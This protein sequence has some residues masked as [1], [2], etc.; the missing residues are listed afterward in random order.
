[1]LSLRTYSGPDRRSATRVPLHAEAIV[2]S[3]GDKHLCT[4]L[5]VSATG[6]SVRIDSL[7]LL[8]HLVEIELYIPGTSMASKWL[9][10]RAAVVRAERNGKCITWGLEF[11]NPGQKNT[12]RIQIYVDGFN[13]G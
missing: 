12:S 6:V 1:M 2:T 3:R 7:A 11:D 5:D 10:A 9:S 13:G 4:A 8:A